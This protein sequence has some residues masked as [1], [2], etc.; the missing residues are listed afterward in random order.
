TDQDYFCSTIVLLSPVATTSARCL[1]KPFLY[2]MVLP[3]LVALSVSTALI[4]TTFFGPPIS[5]FLAASM[6]I[7]LLP[8][9][10]ST[11]SQV[12]VRLHVPSLASME[13]SVAL[14]QS[15]LARVTTVC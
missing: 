2:L 9:F 7:L 8:P 4:S 15:W 13:A 11:D 5:T 14:L 1:V 10:T 3:V 12:F 6:V